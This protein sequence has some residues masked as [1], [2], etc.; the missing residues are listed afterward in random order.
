MNKKIFSLI[1]AITLV[2]VLFAS[3]AAWAKIKTYTG[4]IQGANC[5]VNKSKCPLDNNDAHVALERDFVLLQDNGKYFFLPNIDRST[6]VKHLGDNVKI[7]GELKGERL[8]VSKIAVKAGGSYKTVWDW[9]T[10]ARKI[11][12]GG[13]GR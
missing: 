13:I 11:E 5:V 1:V 2:G 4:T 6:K 8:L 10:I 7:H 9:E 12:S 3:G